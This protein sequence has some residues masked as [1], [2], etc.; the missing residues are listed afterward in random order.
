[1]SGR[2]PTKMIRYTTFAGTIARIKPFPGGYSVVIAARIPAPVRALF[3]EVSHGGTTE[4]DWDPKA[5]QAKVV[6]YWERRH[7]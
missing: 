1:M 4:I 3:S 5:R 7:I 2:S 6:P